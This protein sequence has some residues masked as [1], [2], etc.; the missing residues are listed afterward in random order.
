MNDIEQ[1]LTELST[2]RTKNASTTLSTEYVLQCVKNCTVFLSLM[3]SD[4]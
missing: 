1:Q 2:S 4:K 3:V